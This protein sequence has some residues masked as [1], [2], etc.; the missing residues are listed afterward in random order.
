[1]LITS[2][3]KEKRIGAHNNSDQN[4]SNRPRIDKPTEHILYGGKKF[5]LAEICMS[6]SFGT[7]IVCHSNNIR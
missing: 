5:N 3:L 1:M 7:S 6:R 2:M 4:L